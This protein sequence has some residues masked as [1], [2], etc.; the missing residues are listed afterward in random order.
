MSM[1]HNLAHRGSSAAGTRRVRA[2]VA[3][4]RMPVA[5]LAVALVTAAC[6]STVQIDTATPIGGSLGQPVG[7]TVPGA[8]DPAFVGGT[9][10]DVTAFTGGAT[11]SGAP[12][13]VPDGSGAT[14]GPGP[15]SGSTS[16]AGP[17][18]GAGE[19][20]SAVPVEKGPLAVG[21]MYIEGVDKMASAIGL[22][23][24]SAGDTKAQAQGRSAFA[25]AE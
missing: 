5:A 12:V 14:A 22:S 25:Q 7:A 8:S 10:S 16:G 19:P 3:R 24:L 1:L 4:L 20:T 2:Q 18:S 9:G 13:D 23:A 21:V 11:N 17:S 6:G 15:G